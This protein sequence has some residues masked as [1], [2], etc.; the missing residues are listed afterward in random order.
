MPTKVLIIDDEPQIRRLLKIALTSEKYS[1]A[2][3]DR[4][5]TGLT[6]AALFR[7]DLIVLDL[8]LPDLSG[9]EVIKRLREW[10]DVPVLILSVRSDQVDKITALDG[11][12]DDYL[13]KPFDPSELL[14]RLR[15]LQRRQHS[16]DQPAVVRFGA[17]QVDL[18]SH[19]V[20]REGHEVR[21]T[22]TE[23]ALLSLLIAN[24][25]KIVTHQ[26]VLREIWGPRNEHN[27]NYLRVFM[28]RLRAKLE[29]DPSRPKYF[30]TSSGIGYRLNA[31]AG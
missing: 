18:S 28:T 29:D 21:L 7:P 8:G 19:I 6:E 24:R 14:A 13:T 3:A 11:G 10:S 20:T 5:E 27:T 26:H 17:I 12:A 23:Y 4:G 31:V 15:V 22:A 25:G 2:E 9:L 16:N 1:V 30:L